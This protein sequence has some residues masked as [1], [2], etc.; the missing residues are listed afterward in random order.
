MCFSRG[1][2]ITS[3]T[4]DGFSLRDEP[5]LPFSFLEAPAKPVPPDQSTLP[6]ISGPPTA[7]G[8]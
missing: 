2:P 3:L 1:E 6:V 7:S 4:I 5:I 8:S